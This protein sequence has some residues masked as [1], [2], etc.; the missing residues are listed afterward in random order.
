MAAQKEALDYISTIVSQDK[1]NTDRICSRIIAQVSK[2]LIDG[3][4]EIPS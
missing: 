3:Q 4:A 1:A 2:T